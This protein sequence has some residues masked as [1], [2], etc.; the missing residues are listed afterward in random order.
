MA[1][2]ARPL[3]AAL[4]R[5]EDVA[6][7]D[8]VQE[9]QLFYSKADVSF[10]SSFNPA[11]RIPQGQATVRQIAALYPYD[12]ELYVVEGDGKMVKDA[13]EN[14]AR[15]YLGCEGARCSQPPLI[16]RNVAGFNYDMAEGVD[17][18]IDLTRP[19]GDRVRNLRW[20]GQPLAASQKLHIAVN[21]YRA[22]RERGLFHVRGGQD[23]VAGPGRD[24][25]HDRPLLHRQEEAAG[26]SGQPLARDPGRGAEDSGER[27]AGRGGQAAVAVSGA[28]LLVC[29]LGG[30]PEEGAPLNPTYQPPS[31]GSCLARSAGGL[32]RAARRR[33]RAGY[34]GSQQ[35]DAV[36]LR[37]HR[38]GAGAA[39][40][41]DRVHGRRLAV[42]L[43]DDAQRSVAAVGAEGQA[44]VR[45]ETRGVR[46]RCRSSA[47]RPL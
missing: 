45:V 6:I 13:L 46:A 41:G 33:A 31:C 1:E 25:R 37:I 35:V 8:A 3:S 43:L 39:L 42:D 20:H 15:Y 27:S 12:N 18:E 40:G 11:V 10:A 2:F 44:Q 14:A 29:L 4:G 26:R 24:P 23:R 17:Y 5:V 7:V 19:E 47:S 16:D 21:N 32:A 30:K 34:S 38:H 22:A 36:G 9:A 28:D